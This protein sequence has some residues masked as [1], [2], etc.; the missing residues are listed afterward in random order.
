[1]ARLRAFGGAL[2]RLAADLDAEHITETNSG[3]AIYL[4]SPALVVDAIHEVVDAVR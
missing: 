1:M 2:D 4:Y 3:H